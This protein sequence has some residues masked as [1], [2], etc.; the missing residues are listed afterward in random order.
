VH[1]RPIGQYLGRYILSVRSLYYTMMWMPFVNVSRKWQ[2]QLIFCLYVACRLTLLLLCM[3]QMVWFGLAWRIG[4]KN[5]HKVS[6]QRIGIKNRHKESAQRI[7]TKY[8]HKESAL[9]IGM[10]NRHNILIGKKNSIGLYLGDDVSASG[11][12][13]S[14]K[15]S[16]GWYLGR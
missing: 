14:A 2:F 6:A 12:Q 15:N 3:M 10:K 1:S 4:L 13:V 8:R 11:R 9:R 5:R 16:I 7:G